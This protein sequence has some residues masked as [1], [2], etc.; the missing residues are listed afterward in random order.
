VVGLRDGGRRLGHLCGGEAV[1][2]EVLFRA[3]FP[4]ELP[5]P[6]PGR[7]VGRGG[8]GPLFEKAAAGRNPG[9]CIVWRQD[10]GA[11]A[12]QFAKT[13]HVAEKYRRADGLRFENGQP[14]SLVQRW[15]EYPDGILQ[16]AG[17]VSFRNKRQE[18]DSRPDGLG[19]RTAGRGLGFFL[20][21]A[22]HQL[23]RRMVLFVQRTDHPQGPVEPFVYCGSTDIDEVRRPYL[24]RAQLL[25]KGRRGS[26][27][28][29]L[30]DPVSDDVQP[31]L[32]VRPKRKNALS[33]L[34][35]DGD[36]RFHSFEGTGNELVEIPARMSWADILLFERFPRQDI[37]DRH[38]RGSRLPERERIACAM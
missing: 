11:G 10:F 4:G 1:D 9:M 34:I 20:N 25:G 6:L 18:H 17:H 32:E 21:A 15:V 28:V 26:F 8:F 14:K 38:N 13:A 24:H 29:R 33:G 12:L 35:A 2:I 36:D 7:L 19:N 23:P 31:R 30:S 27:K 3:T 37:M 5:C 16:E 22:H